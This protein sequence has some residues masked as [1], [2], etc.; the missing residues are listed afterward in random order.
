MAK[1]NGYNNVVK[2][3]FGLGKNL[4]NIVFE[5]NVYWSSSFEQTREQPESQSE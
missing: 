2:E 1:F 4:I 3:Y 5:L